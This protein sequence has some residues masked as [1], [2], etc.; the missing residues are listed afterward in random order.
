MH[1]LDRAVAVEEARKRANA[2]LELLLA[3]H[4]APLLD[5][6]RAITSDVC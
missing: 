2:E 5:S 3:D 4:W 6:V 1:I